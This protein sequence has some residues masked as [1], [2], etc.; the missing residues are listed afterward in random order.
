[1]DEHKENINSKDSNVKMSDTTE[2]EKVGLYCLIRRLTYVH[3]EIK[4]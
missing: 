2:G 4:C 1:M 3:G